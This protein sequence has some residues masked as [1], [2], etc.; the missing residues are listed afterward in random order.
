MRN[1][2]LLNGSGHLVITGKNKTA[3]ITV[4]GDYAAA[5]GFGSSQRHVH[6]DR[7]ACQRRQLFQRSSTSSAGSSAAGTNSATFVP[8]SGHPGVVRHSKQFGLR[9]ANRRHR[10]A[11]LASSG[12]AGSILNML[13]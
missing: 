1:V 10:R 4:S 7:S 6:A 5:L 3:T 9:A 2:T 11:L 13:A 12:S 8:Q